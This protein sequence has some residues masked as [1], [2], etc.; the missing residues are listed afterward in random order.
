MTMTPLISENPQGVK[1]GT[2][3]IHESYKSYKFYMSNK[4]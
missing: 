4:S 2:Y 3:R 1:S